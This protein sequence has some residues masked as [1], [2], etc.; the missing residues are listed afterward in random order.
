[1][2]RSL[3]S[4]ALLVSSAGS[5]SIAQ[6]ASVCRPPAPKLVLQQRQPAGQPASS[7]V[8]CRFCD[9]GPCAVC[10]N[11]RYLFTTKV[12]ARNGGA[13]ATAAP[14]VTGEDSLSW[15]LQSA[16][17]QRL[18]EAAEEVELSKQV[19]QLISWDRTAAALRERL[20]RAPSDEEMAVQL[21][22]PGGAPEYA[23][24]V[25]RLRAGRKLLI[26]SNLL[27]VVSVAKKYTNRGLAL[28][29]MIQE[30][31][32]GLMKA[33][34][35]FEAA[36]SLRFST[37]ATWWIR[38]EVMRA[39]AQQSR[40]I[41]LP[42]KVHQEINTLRRTRRD[43]ALQLDRQPTDDE[44]AEQ[45]RITVNKL[46]SID[47]SRVTV[48]TVSMNAPLVRGGVGAKLGTGAPTS[49]EQVLHDPK[50]HPD[51]SCVEQMMQES[52]RAEIAQLIDATLTERESRVLRMRYG[53]PLDDGEAMDGDAS[54][55]TP[56]LVMPRE[57]ASRLSIS[58]PAVRS[59]LHR[60]I[61]KL[62]ARATAS[63][64]LA[65]CEAF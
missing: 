47:K 1:M 15:Y 54:A 4:A 36:R 57:I 3:L 14:V 41:R 60:A 8:P 38:G 63:P 30:G 10:N 32:L 34:E 23:C 49:L 33:A 64:G 51:E 59:I 48:T 27:L 50:P 16:G 22:L 20:L 53:L 6:R 43:L 46:R 56:S 5:A 7:T 2:R 12:S 26:S 18:L 19:Q 24:E 55:G 44:I 45:M 21:E 9:D 42:E 39:I 61:T 13:T 62:R 31:S 52:L 37:Y 11:K 35:K 28:Q 40:T 17:E 25:E 65:A 29:D 58:H